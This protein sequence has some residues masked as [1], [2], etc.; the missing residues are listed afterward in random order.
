[1][2]GEILFSAFVSLVLLNLV[3]LRVSHLLANLLDLVG[4]PL[5]KALH[6][7]RARWL[8]ILRQ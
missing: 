5:T 8:V 6:H 7:S 3:M 4:D 1:M 2:D